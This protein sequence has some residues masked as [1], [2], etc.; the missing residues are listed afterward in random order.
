MNGNFF[1]MII[2]PD[3]IQVINPALVF[4]LIPGFNKLFY[5]WFSKC[6]IIENS[7]QRMAIG[8]IAAGLAFFTAGILELALEKTYPQLPDKQHAFVNMINT[9][10]CDVKIRN[11]FNKEQVVHSGAM[12]LYK[13]IACETFPTYTLAIKAPV[14]CGY[15]HLTTSTCSIQMSCFEFQVNNRIKY[16]T[17]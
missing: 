12:F 1:G 15:I 5:P 14:Q 11:H 10:P 9:L 2:I 17:N 6:R 7:L 13:N 4:L 8:G 16:C 3:Q